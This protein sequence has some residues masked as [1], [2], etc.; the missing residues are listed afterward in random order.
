MLSLRV[1]ARFPPENGRL[2]ESDE[3]NSRQ[4]QDIGTAY[5]D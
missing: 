5:R 3:V 4:V 1:D 2:S